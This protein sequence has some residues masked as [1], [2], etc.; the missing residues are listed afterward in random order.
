MSNLPLNTPPTDKERLDHLASLPY[1]VRRG[2]TQAKPMTVGLWDEAKRQQ[3][4]LMDIL[5]KAG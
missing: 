1:S 5:Y 3:M 2:I 4:D